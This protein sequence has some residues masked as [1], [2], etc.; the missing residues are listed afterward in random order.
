MLAEAL[1]F[2]MRR[3]EAMQEASQALMALPRLGADVFERGQAEGLTVVARATWRGTLP[4]L[5]RAYGALSRRRAKST[6]FTIEE[7]RLMSIEAAIERLDR[8][9]G[10]LGDWRPFLSLL[11]GGY[12]DGIERRSVTAAT[13]VA[14]LE[15]AKS[16]R[17]SI[18]QDGAFAPIFLRARTDRDQD[19]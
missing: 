3:L 13:L 1:A 14:A 2:Q 9:L 6:V 16:G 4:E 5:L 7:T 11:P 17:L 8:M 12:G 10:A 19:A 18:R 15:M